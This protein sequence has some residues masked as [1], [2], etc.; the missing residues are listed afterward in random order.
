MA[1]DCT[2]STREGGKGME[3]IKKNVK[4]VAPLPKGLT[5]TSGETKTHMKNHK[6]THL[7]YIHISIL[8]KYNLP[9]V[10]V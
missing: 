4:T 8:G 2:Q 9:C 5:S 10:V 1:T 3:V 6:S 7:T